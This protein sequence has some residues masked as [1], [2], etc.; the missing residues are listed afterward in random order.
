MTDRLSLRA[1][2]AGLLVLSAALFFVGI[3]LERAATTDSGPA[4]EH[5]G[6]SPHVEGDEGEAGEGGGAA[7][8][9]QPAENGETP[10]QHAAEVQPLGIDLES[11]FLVGGAIIVSLVLAVAVVRSVNPIIPI[12]IIAFSILFA[13]LDVLELVYQIGESRMG[14]ALFAAV[15][16]AIHVAAALIALRLVTSGR[17]ARLASA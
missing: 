10:E 17:G 15:L 5:P 2:L 14:L 11:S 4:V 7:Q 1:W 12:G 16:A 3:Y 6:P 8:P 13:V 9:T